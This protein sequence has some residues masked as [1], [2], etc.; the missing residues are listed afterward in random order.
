MIVDDD[1]DV[2][3]MPWKGWP[4]D[5]TE[6]AEARALGVP[7]AELLGDTTGRENLVKERDLA[8]TRLTPAQRA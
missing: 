8:V 4:D 1:P 3:F 2:V 7:V 5:D 6:R